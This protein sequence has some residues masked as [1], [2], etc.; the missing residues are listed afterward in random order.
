M[1]VTKLNTH[2]MDIQLR[3]LFVKVNNVHILSIKA[4]HTDLGRISDLWGDLD[5]L[6]DL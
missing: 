4:I 2:L 6:S 3:L 1:E 5:Q